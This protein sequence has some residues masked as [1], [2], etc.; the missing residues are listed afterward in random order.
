MRPPTLS[1]R[2][3]DELQWNLYTDTNEML[4]LSLVAR[5]LDNALTL[6]SDFMVSE[7][8]CVRACVCMCV[9]MCVGVHVCVRVCIVCVHVCVCVYACVRVCGAYTCSL[10]IYVYNY[11]ECTVCTYGMHTIYSDA[12]NVHM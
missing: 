7:A 6:R 11:M 3:P 12:K 1:S 5:T 2:S 4:N 10:Y 9:Y 8:V